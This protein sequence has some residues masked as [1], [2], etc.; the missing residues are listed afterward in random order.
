M[1]HPAPTHLGRDTQRQFTR[2]SRDPP[3]RGSKRR[4][5]ARQ[6]GACCVLM[7]TFPLRSR[8]GVFSNL[9]S[10]GQRSASGVLSSCPS[11]AATTWYSSPRG[12]TTTTVF[13]SPGGG[14]LYDSIPLWQKRST[15]VVPATLLIGRGGDGATMATQ[16]AAPCRLSHQ[17]ESTTPALPRGTCRTSPSHLRRRRVSLP[18]DV[19]APSG[20]MTPA[21]SRRALP[22][23][24]RR[25]C[26]PPPTRLHYRPTTKRYRPFSIP[27]LFGSASIHLATPLW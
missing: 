19:S 22:S 5:L 6:V 14:E 26:A 9:S 27:Y 2:R 4:Q 15:P 18:R 8:W 20:L 23:Y 17:S 3:P 25:R 16:E 11:T 21:P 13:A 24:L 12:V 10:P 1:F 7:N